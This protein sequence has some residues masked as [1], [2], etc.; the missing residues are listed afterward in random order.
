MSAVVDEL[1]VAVRLHNAVAATR[2][3]RDPNGRRAD[4]QFRKRRLHVDPRARAELDIRTLLDV[5]PGR[6]HDD[7]RAGVAAEPPRVLVHLLILT[8]H[9]SALSPRRE[10]VV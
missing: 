8:G 1:T 6:D 4:E 7:R 9:E 5:V 3:P 2:L 10:A